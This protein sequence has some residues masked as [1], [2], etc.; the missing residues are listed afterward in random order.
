MQG[1]NCI[2]IF[3]SQKSELLFIKRLKDPYKGLYNFV[4]GKIEKEEDGFVAAYRELYEETGI[5]SKD[6]KLYHMMDFK[7]YNQDC[8]VEVYVG[9]LF[10]EIQLRQE[11]HPLY[12]LPISEDFFDMRKFAGEGNIGHMVE[13]VKIYGLGILQSDI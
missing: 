5:S 3:N 13:Q 9:I 4:G 11:L 2:M 12:W 1:Y 10:N 6:I 8:Y 7:Y